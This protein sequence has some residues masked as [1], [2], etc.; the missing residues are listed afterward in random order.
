MEDQSVSESLDNSRRHHL[1]MVVEVVESLV[2][3][4]S[5]AVSVSEGITWGQE[6]RSDELERLSS[7]VGISEIS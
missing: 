3:T 1:V 4:I 2:E 6:L 5:E 7:F